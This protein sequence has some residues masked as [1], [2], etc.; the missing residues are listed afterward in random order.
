[1][2]GKKYLLFSLVLMVFTLLA[3]IHTLFTVFGIIVVKLLIQAFR[4]EDV[5]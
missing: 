3:A 5:S 1:M 2:K 4:K